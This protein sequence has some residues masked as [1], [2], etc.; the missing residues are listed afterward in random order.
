[1]EI[2]DQYV[3]SAPTHQNALDLFQ[4]EWSSQLPP[5]EG[6]LKAGQIPLFEDQ[7]IVWAESQ[8]GGFDGC[9]ILELGP[10][11]GG[12]TYMLEKMGA[13]SILSIEANARAFLKCLIVKEILNLTRSR[14]LL[15]D[16]LEYLRGTKESFDVCLASG[17]LYHM[18]D[19]VELLHLISRVSNKIILWTHY[20]DPEVIQRDPR[21]SEKFSKPVRSRYKEFSSAFYKYAYKDALKWAGF[22]GGSAA[23]SSW[24]S[25]EDILCCLKHLGY[26][27]LRIGF[28][29]PNHPNGPALCVAGIRP[30]A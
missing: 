8:L 21:L 1:M 25:R 23:F 14:F 16:F 15:G 28:D 6:P 18:R 2:L 3:T 30:M 4:G 13:D 7:R 22:C 5:E 17:V 26:S 11:E 29:H 24:M 19:P 10:L 27:D 9:R 20:Y 12:H